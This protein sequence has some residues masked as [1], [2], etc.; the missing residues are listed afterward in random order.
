MKFPIDLNKLH[1][2][3][4]RKSCD[5]NK[6]LIGSLILLVCTL[7]NNI[8]PAQAEGSR[9]L[10]SDGGDRPYI[11]WSDGTTAGISRKTTLKVFVQKDEIVNLGSSVHTSSDSKDIVYRSPFGSQ[12]GT[13]DVK[14]TGFGLID[15][16]TKETKGP[17]VTSG[18]GGYKPCTFIAQETGIYEV[19][20]H[21]PKTSGDPPAIS[22]SAAFPIDA[23][24]G[25]GVAAWDITIKD[26]SNNTK[27]GRVF[28][29]YVAMNMGTAARSL[30]SK[31]YIQTKDGYRYETDMNGVDPYGFIFFGNSRGYIDQTNKSTVYH[32]AKATDN[33]LSS[34][35]GNIKVQS[36][37]IPDTKTDITHL[38]FFNRPDG[39][40][41]DALNIP[42]IPIPPATPT[43]FKFTG[44]T[45]GSGNQTPVGEGG[46]F[47]FVSS[48]EGTYQITI[49]T[50]NDGIYD[51]SFDRILENPVSMGTNVVFWDGKDA[52]GLNV[53]AL[54]G[55]APYNAQVTIRGGEYHFPMLDA[56]NNPS[57]F[58]ITMENSP[59]AFPAIKDRNGQQ[60]GPT[61]IYYNDDNYK[62]GDGTTVDLS[63]SG[64][65]TPSN[66]ARGI[67]SALGEHKFSSNYGD[68]KGIDTWSYFPSA[69]VLA[70]LVI[71]EKNQ[72][73]VKGRKSV[74][75]L[76]DADNSN[77][78]TVGDTVE[79]EITY[80]NL[81]P[82]TSDAIKFEI[83]DN[84]PAQLAFKNAAI[85]NQ[86]S[87]NTIILNPNYNGTGK[88]TNSG[89][90][91]IGDSI[92]ITITATINSSNNGDPITNQASAIFATP[93]NPIATVGNI[94]TDA[95]SASGTTETPTVGNTFLQK[96]DNVDMG[97]DPNNKIDDDPTLFKVVKGVGKLT[98]VKRVT[99]I[100]NSTTYGTVDLTQVVDDPNTT[101][102]NN[103]QWGTNY[104]QGGLSGLV[105]KPGDEVEYTIYYLS[106]G[107]APL[108]SVTICDLIPV[109]ST[110]VEN[111]FATATGISMANI[112]SITNLTNAADSDAGQF[113]S[114]NNQAPG[115]CNRTYIQS[116]P[117]MS[118]V[119]PLAATSNTT[120]AVLVNLVTNTQTLTEGD[121]GFIRFRTKV[122]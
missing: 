108:N 33:T 76:T 28:T 80:S 77:S 105:V 117:N 78:L 51:P 12:N 26:S 114:T 110:F 32:S 17:E 27:K 48:S 30:N 2:F 29:N 99:R 25:M 109:N 6:Q 56:E 84:L 98:L 19:E 118:P 71:T 59:G 22:G 95:D 45:G 65:T 73:N 13:C 53:T 49:D 89:I 83:T 24:Q 61:T 96:D 10:V 42:R 44:K 116:N 106:S 23:T 3:S 119:P 41:L 57:G 62:T 64:A 15:T 92:T 58:K 34:F 50:N 20:F 81:T 100:N 60:I 31:L 36:P 69:T 121:R 82:S 74:R 43:N 47:S 37:N 111:G 35:Q 39:S 93:E 16:T 112:L 72:A 18:D 7:G 75:F 4:Q 66:A 79:Y 11:E 85:K 113:I 5:R 115:V 38:V 101:D 46:Y 87:G 97:N 14:T 104:L 8:K 107:K 67:N 9:E 122:N 40:T 94:V 120:G 70:P 103:T 52:K 86:T 21:A 55:N 91:R 90:L 1:K 88:L 102:D 68:F 54:S 63:G